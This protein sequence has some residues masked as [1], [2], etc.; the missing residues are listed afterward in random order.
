MGGDEPPAD[1]EP[2]SDSTTQPKALQ[3]QLVN[4]ADHG[5]IIL[6]V[7][8][9]T[10]D[11][12][13]RRTRKAALASRKPSN[14]NNHD[15]AP[16]MTPRLTIS[17]RVTLSALKHHSKY[18]ANLLTNPSFREAQLIA[19]VHAHLASRNIKPGEAEA[20]DLPRI[21]ITDDDD[22]T[23]CAG[24][25]HAFEDMLRLVHQKSIKT[26]RVTM[27][28]VT[29]LA[30]IADRFDCTAAVS[31]ALADMKFKWPLTSTKPY[32]DD[33]GRVTEV[34]KVLRQKVLVAWLLSQPMRLH[35]SSK[36]LLMRGSRL[37]GQPYGYEEGHLCAA[38][39]NLPEGIEEELQH[40]RECI[41]NT[42]SSIQSHFLALYSSRDRQCKLGYDSSAACDSFQFGQMLKFLL[43]KDLLFL[44]DFSPASVDRLP[45][46]SLLDVDELLSTLKQC[47]NYQVDKHH[48]NCGLRIR[49]D[50]I[51]D[52]VKAMV[53]ASVVSIP[54]ADWTRRR[55]DVSWVSSTQ[56]DTT[57]RGNRGDDVNDNDDD[58]RVFAFTR[59]LANDQ[60]LRYEG[61]IYADRM[62]K[63]LFTADGWNWTPEL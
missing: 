17:Y 55:A 33:S 2:P 42:I 34:E 10:S 39:W 21:L 29:T 52:Y 3:E 8:F 26:T 61:A 16:A 18:F 45:D 41:L 62:A 57:Y 5:D 11:A 36:E 15:P 1:G 43:S 51:L 59:A 24:R 30:I 48:L 28:Y 49:I 23:Q 27:S 22:A 19:A 37:W 38:W 46:I 7:T 20:P 12:T 63:S 56:A 14:S 58:K 32:M 53:S 4:V 40:R 9:I 54:H 47:P 44:V 35:Q 13:L 50:P 6:S 60:R 25:E 31:R